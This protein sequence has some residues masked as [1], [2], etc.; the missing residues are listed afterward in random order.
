MLPCEVSSD[1]S[2]SP[3]F[4]WF[5]NGKAIDFSRQENF[6]MIGGVSV[7]QLNTLRGIRAKDMTYKHYREWLILKLL[8]AQVFQPGTFLQWCGR[9]LT[10]GTD[11]LTNHITYIYRYL[12]IIMIFDGS[13]P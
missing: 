3:T 12:D 1:P 2:L 11:F 13:T 8:T 10:T 7:M 6:E 5:F 4:K 9:A